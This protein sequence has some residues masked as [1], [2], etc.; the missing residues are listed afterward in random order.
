MRL[1]TTRFPASFLP[2]QQIRQ[3]RNIGRDAARFV[4]A[5]ASVV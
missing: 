4:L 5:V 1:W 2:F 3:H